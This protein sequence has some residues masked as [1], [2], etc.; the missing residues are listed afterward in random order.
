[1]EIGEKI[2]RVLNVDVPEKGVQWGKYLRV[3][4]RVDATKKLVRGKKVT[5]E[6]GGSRWVFFK[7]ER[8]PNFCY[9]CGRLDQGVKDWKEIVGTEN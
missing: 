7:Y 2:G 6:G 3:R 5:I 8:L 1:M 4:V 9:Q